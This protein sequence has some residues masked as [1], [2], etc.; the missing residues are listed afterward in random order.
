MCDRMV[1]FYFSPKKGNGVG[2]FYRVPHK[3]RPD[4][5]QTQ[6][7]PSPTTFRRVDREAALLSCRG[8]A[9]V[10]SRGT[11]N[12]G[13]LLI[14]ALPLVPADEKKADFLKGNVQRKSVWGYS[15]NKT[16]CVSWFEEFFSHEKRDDNE[17]HPN[18]EAG[19]RLAD[20]KTERRDSMRLSGIGQSVRI[21]DLR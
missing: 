7:D 13:S 11:I 3:A 12:P 19:T 9:F 21:N 8:P 2:L 1:S 10:L 6:W 20:R 17:G 15:G 18:F 16:K 4:L 14:I 5:G